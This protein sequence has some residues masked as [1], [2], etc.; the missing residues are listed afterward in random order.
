MTQA[1]GIFTFPSTGTWEINLMQQGLSN[2][3]GTGIS[4]DYTTNNSTYGQAAYFDYWTG[5]GTADPGT[6]VLS[7]IVTVTSTTNN[8]VRVTAYGISYAGEAVTF[9]TFK[10]LA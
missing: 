1:S 4:I 8:K 2:F 3:S 6:S 9:L 7:T 5:G 10:K